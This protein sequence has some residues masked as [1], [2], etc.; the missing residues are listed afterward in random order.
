[1]GKTRGVIRKIEIGDLLTKECMRVLNLST[2]DDGLVVN[3]GIVM[4]WHDLSAISLFNPI[5]YDN[6][7]ID[8]VFFFGDGTIEFY[9]E[10]ECDAKNWADFSNDYVLMIIEELRKNQC[11]IFA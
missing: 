2:N 4:E 7:R 1:M 9:F 6:D 10:K 5:P 11:S 3:N 8:G